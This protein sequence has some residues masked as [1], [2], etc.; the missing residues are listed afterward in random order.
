MTSV[1][2]LDVD[3]LVMRELDVLSLLED[4][5]IDGRDELARAFDNEAFSGLVFTVF[6]LVNFN[7]SNK[8]VLMF[9]EDVD[10]LD[11]LFE[12]FTWLEEEALFSFSE[13]FDAPSVLSVFS[14]RIENNAVL[15]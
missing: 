11:A 7:S 14:N 10:V 6:V 12:R 4:L 2:S 8:K 15:S 9:V 1:L 3:A 13:F 5:D